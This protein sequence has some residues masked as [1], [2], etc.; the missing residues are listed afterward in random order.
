MHGSCDCCGSR[1]ACFEGETYCPDCTYYEA[2][3]LADQADDEARRERQA[4][5][6]ADDG[7]P[8]DG[9]PW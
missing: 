1:L 7:P 2:L 9:C 3:Q 4:P 6:P 5:A 8:D